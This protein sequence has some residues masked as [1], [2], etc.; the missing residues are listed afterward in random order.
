MAK[1]WEEVTEEIAELENEARD[2]IIDECQHENV[3]VTYHTA[4]VVDGI[5]KAIRYHCEDCGYKHERD[6]QLYPEIWDKRDITGDPLPAQQGRKLQKLINTGFPE[7][8]HERV[9]AP[10]F[11]IDSVCL[12]CGI[13]WNK[14]KREN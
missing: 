1:A 5:I 6:G 14:S 13:L 3:T 11:Y 7:C 4:I 12:D 10:E 9:T 8:K 2:K